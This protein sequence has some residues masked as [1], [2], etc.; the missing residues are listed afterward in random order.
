MIGALQ[1][2]TCG[3][4][5]KYAAA[6]R[7]RL[8]PPAEPRAKKLG[9][10]GTISA[11]DGRGFCG[12]LPWHSLGSFGKSTNK[13]TFRSLVRSRNDSRECVLHLS[14]GSG[15]WAGLITKFMMG[16]STWSER[17]LKVP[18]F[19][20]PASENPLSVVTL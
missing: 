4:K 5:K 14:A 2:P 12:S 16:V 3:P 7:C 10:L 8:R 9:K 19:G 13:G 6:S 15:S 17:G 20:E 11:L 18:L 1:A